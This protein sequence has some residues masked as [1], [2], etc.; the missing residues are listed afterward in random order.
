MESPMI[1]RLVDE[2]N[3]P[4]VNANN[5]NDILAE[6]GER[7]LFLTGDRLGKPSSV[8]PPPRCICRCSDI[9]QV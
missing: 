7:V 9:A 2:L 5:L 4:R 1:E 6:A 3:Y 8:R